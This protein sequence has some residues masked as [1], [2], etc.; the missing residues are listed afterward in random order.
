M[1]HLKCPLLASNAA[2]TFALSVPALCS[3]KFSFCCINVNVLCFIQ[4]LVSNLFCVALLAVQVSLL[5]I[6]L[7]QY[8]LSE[9]AINH[10]VDKSSGHC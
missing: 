6:M 4:R 1:Q 3:L 8:C 5:E 10:P 2:R 7:K 9:R